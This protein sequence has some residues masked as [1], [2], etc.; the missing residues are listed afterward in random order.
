MAGQ[1]KADCGR[2]ANQFS[3]SPPLAA[4]TTPQE[5]SGARDTDASS[6]VPDNRVPI[7]GDPSIVG[8]WHT[9]FIFGRTASRRGFRP[10]ERRWERSTERRPAAANRQCLSG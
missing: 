6:I 3:V 10:M 2:M 4:L 5:I 7:D 1:A 9:K 8:L